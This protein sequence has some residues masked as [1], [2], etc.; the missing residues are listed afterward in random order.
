MIDDGVIPTC[1]P[2]TDSQE[3]AMK[4]LDDSAIPSPNHE[5]VGGIAVGSSANSTTMTLISPPEWLPILI[6]P[7]FMSNGLEVHESKIRPSWQGHRIWMN[8]SSLGMSAMYFGKAQQSQTTYDDDDNEDDDSEEQ[9]QKKYKSA[10]LE[11]MRLNPNDMITDP[12]G[13]K[14]RPISGLVGVDYLAP[15]IFTSHVSYVFGPV[16]QALQEVGYKE[17]VNLQAANYDW[18]LPPSQLEKRDGYFTR[19]IQQVEDLYRNNHST[20]VVLLGHSLG[21]KTAHY[22]LNFCLQEKG[23]AWIDLHIHTYLPVGAPHLGAPKGL[24]SLVVGEK[25]GLDTFLSDEEGLTMGRSFG[26]GPWMLPQDLPAGVP[27]SVYVLPHGVLE[28]SFEYALN[29]QELVNK[30]Q[31]S[32]KPKR[33]QLVVAYGKEQRKISTPFY[34]TSS[35]GQDA[36]AFGDKTSFATEPKPGS[37]DERV[38]QFFLQEPG[39]AAAKYETAEEKSCNPLRC[40]LKWLCCCCICVYIYELLRP[41]M[42]LLI[43]SIVTSADALTKSYDRGTNLAFSDPLVIP[44]QVWDGKTVDLEV[45]LYHKDDYGKYEGWSCC[46]ALKKARTATLHIKVKWFPYDKEKSFRSI[47]SPICRSDPDGE[48]LKIRKK[49]KEYQEFSGYD[50]LEREG[51]KTTLQMIRDMYDSDATLGPR[52]KSSCDAPPVK[53]VHAIYGINLP[54][55]IGGVYKRKDVCLSECRLKSFFKLDR[56][57]SLDPKMGYVVEGGLLLET[58][59]THQRAADGRQASGDGTV[60]YWSLQHCKTWK[61]P[62]REVTVVELERAEH[63]GILADSRFHEELLKYCRIKKEAV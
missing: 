51:L 50:I 32:S 30:R 16:I 62:D 25:M 1:S 44:K 41:L 55:E 27:S 48:P 58:S 63:R 54:T 22:F 18:R 40:C 34:R 7:G 42:C 46:L 31:A 2:V 4:E 60:P 49:E 15:G 43:R 5:E 3:P 20:P 8:L 36:V 38:V 35:K 47:C 28:I 59:K 12:N 23:Q 57:A 29:T 33:Y 17:G 6:I 21:C 52:S 19:T 10:W 13:V 53:R 39:L 45:P 9:Q 11:H 56:K 26:S 37:P 14:I 24:R 61:A